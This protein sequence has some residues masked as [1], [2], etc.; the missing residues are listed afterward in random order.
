MFNKV[1]I[2]RPMSENIQKIVFDSSQIKNKKFFYFFV[3]IFAFLPLEWQQCSFLEFLT[4]RVKKNHTLWYKSQVA[5]SKHNTTLI[6]NKFT[7]AVHTTYKSILLELAHLDRIYI[8]YISTLTGVM[9]P[10]GVSILI[11]GYTTTTQIAWIVF[12]L[13]VVFFVVCTCRKSTWHILIKR[14]I[15]DGA[16]IV[17]SI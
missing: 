11:F 1:Y 12:V 6:P 8:I 5:G 13:F 2:R 17:M 15:I 16:S 7:C 10:V 4:Y 3:D 9:I 14:L